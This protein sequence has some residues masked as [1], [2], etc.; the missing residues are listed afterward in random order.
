MAKVVLTHLS[1][2]DSAGRAVL[3]G[4][5]LEVADREL[6]AVI[7]PAGADQE[8]LLR[9]IAGLES[10]T[11]GD[12]FI[13]ERRVNSLAPKARDVAMVFREASLYPAMTVRENIAFGLRQRGFSKEKTTTHVTDTARA[14]QVE[15]LLDQKPATLSLAQSQRV[16]IARAIA[17][18]PKVLL[19]DDPLRHLFP[20]ER[21][22]LRAELRQLHERIKITTILAASD[23]GEALS[24]GERV[25]VLDE[26]RAVQHEDAA[27]VYA[28]PANIRAAQLSGTPPIN[29]IPGTLRKEGDGLRF[30]EADGGT[31]AATLPNL[32]ATMGAERAGSAVILG[33]RPEDIELEE[34]A[35]GPEAEAPV[36]PMIA[37]YVE[38]RGGSA[39]LH[40]QTGAHDLICLSRGQSDM[41]GLG[42]RVRV[43]MN[44]AKAHLF[45]PASGGRIA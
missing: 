30:V 3:H 9:V 35:H 38:P 10:P 2:N 33:V 7:G 15:G 34:F 14:L 32:A 16:A 40:L 44:L 24:L 31:I 36:F 6:L 23:P 39:L 45:D 41:A 11:A 26:G 43:R 5:N 42:R 37:D 8:T 12:I 27:S 28:R 19:L 29:L 17:W 21:A 22:K 20:E 13:G 1:A 18:Q 4:I 25:L